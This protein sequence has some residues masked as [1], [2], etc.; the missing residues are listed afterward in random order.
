MVFNK[1]PQNYQFYARGSNNMAN[2]PLK[3]IIEL[4]NWSYFSVVVTKEGKPYTYVRSN[5]DYTLGPKLGTFAMQIP[6]KCELAEYE[7]KFYAI[8]NTS[9]SVL[10]ATRTNLLVGDA[11]VV[12]GQSNSYNGWEFSQSYKGKY[13]RSFGR[14]YSDY[15]NVE[16]YQ[17]RDTTWTVANN[18]SPVGMWV[19]EIMK[20]MIERDNIPICVINGG[21]GGSSMEYNLFRDPQN[22]FAFNAP[23]GRLLYRV[24]KAGLR[25][26]I[27]AYIYRQG[28]NDA[29]ANYG[30]FWKDLFLQHV[31][32]LKKEYPALEKI[33]LTQINV[34]SGDN[35]MQGKLREM[36]R[37]LITSNGFIKGFSTIGLPA[38]DG[39]HYG[40]EGNKQAAL[41]MYRIL[42]EDFLGHPKNPLHYSPNIVSIQYLNKE[43]TKI[44]LEFDKGQQILTPNDTLVTTQNNQKILK[45]VYESFYF[46]P[47]GFP[48]ET[49]NA[50]FINKFT[51]INH[52]LVLELNKA[53]EKDI[54]SYLPSYSSPNY[55]VFPFAGPY[56]K[57]TLGMRAFSFENQPILPYEPNNPID[58]DDDGLTEEK[59]DCPTIKNP[60]KPIIK[61]NNQ[62]DLSVAT[63]STFQWYYNGQSIPGGNS[64]TFKALQS[65]IYSVRVKD[66][67]GCQSTL[68]DNYQL[69]I[70]ETKE[71]VDF[72]VYPNPAQDHIRLQ[73]PKE[74]GTYC[75]IELIEISGRVIFTKSNV[76]N[77]QLLPT[78]N[79]P[80]GTYIF[81]LVS[82]GGKIRNKSILI[83]H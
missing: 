13:T 41:E 39:I 4:E 75:S 83:N 50:N 47:K 79:I 33:Y 42:G 14:L 6:L 17:E 40:F 3:G 28:E 81:R 18:G 56:I 57:N 74:F 30:I 61:V 26:N 46:E 20:L 24:E 78:E 70:T 80:S 65:G 68:S 48:T 66:Q 53:P 16:N 7:M 9:D 67:Y 36:Q 23:S 52:Y 69:L 64:Q 37:S 5:F 45:K 72:S 21:S 63:G 43:K 51:G 55:A 32:E 54:V 29:N 35:L 44:V 59:D 31:N 1:L 15:S 58:V 34:I 19:G 12:S 62:V 25:N 60:S 22:T 8:R 73:F 2:V 82:D 27:K 77:G 71:D 11:Y 10:M 49:S 38:Y 76:I